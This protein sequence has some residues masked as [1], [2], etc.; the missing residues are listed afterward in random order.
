MFGIGVNE[1]FNA[2][3]SWTVMFIPQ[4]LALAIACLELEPHKEKAA[5]VSGTVFLL[6]LAA[7][8][9]IAAVLDVFTYSE[10]MAWVVIAVL[11][12]PHFVVYTYGAIRGI[13]WF[14][15]RAVDI[16]R[17]IGHPFCINSHCEGNQLLAK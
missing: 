13:L 2:H 3:V 4:S 7:A 1:A 15:E 6:N 8:T 9:A 14:K 10:A 5:N 12:L 11:M 16:Y 17:G